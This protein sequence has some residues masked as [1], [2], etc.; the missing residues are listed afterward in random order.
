MGDLPHLTQCVPNGFFPSWKQRVAVI[1]TE[2]KC[3]PSMLYRNASNSRDHS[4]LLTAS[5]SICGAELSAER[6][7]GML[8]LPAGLISVDLDAPLGFLSARKAAPA[9]VSIFIGG[10][11]WLDW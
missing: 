9:M 3:L 8:R 7:S 10:Q 11:S 4:Q 6:A 1:R 2:R 5:H